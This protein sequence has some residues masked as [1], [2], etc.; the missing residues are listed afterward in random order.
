MTRN[1]DFRITLTC[2]CAVKSRLSP[3]RTNETYACTTGLGHG[4]RL[5]WTSW[6]DVKTGRASENHRPEP[7]VDRPD[8]RPCERVS[9]TEVREGDRLHFA[10]QMPHR[11]SATWRDGVVASV[12]PDSVTVD[13]GEGDRSARLDRRTWT[14]RAVTRYT[15]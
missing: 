14:S 11:R 1:M 13:C 5:A 10:T 9:F 4:Y 6:T 8:P 2:G 3:M 12:R 7:A 15:D